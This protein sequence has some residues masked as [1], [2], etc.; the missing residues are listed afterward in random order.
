MFLKSQTR[1]AHLFIYY[2]TAG[3][4]QHLLRQT[5]YSEAFFKQLQAFTTEGSATEWAPFSSQRAE[6]FARHRV[7]EGTSN[8]AN[9][10]YANRI[11]QD[12][13]EKF[14]NSYYCCNS[15]NIFKFDVFEMKEKVLPELRKKEMEEKVLP[16]T[17]KLKNLQLWFLTLLCYQLGPD[18]YFFA[19]LYINICWDAAHKHSSINIL[20]FFKE[21]VFCNLGYKFL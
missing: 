2:F 9:F 15:Q 8:K 17:G 19:G 7:I 20:T 12:L 5:C 18:L 11:S 21:T 13:K 10:E 14:F 16:E 3:M 1:L 4:L 6:I